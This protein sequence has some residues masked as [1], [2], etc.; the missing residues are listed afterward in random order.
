[1]EILKT[2]NDINLILGNTQDFKVDAGWDQNLQE[3]EKE[4]LEKIINPVENYETVRYIHKPYTSPNGVYQSD[5][6]FYFYFLNNTTGYTNGLD[7]S[8]VGI[9]PKENAKMLKQSTESFFRL[10]F[11]KTPNND[12]PDRTNRRLVFTK[13]LSLPLGEKFYYTTLNDF[14]FVPVFMGNNYKNTENMYLFWFQ[15]DTPFEETTITGNTFWMTAKFYNGKDGSILDFTTTGLTTSQEVNET[16]DMYYQ[17]VIDRTNYTYQ[18]FRYNGSVGSRIGLNNDP[19][20]F[21]EKI[22]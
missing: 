8:L 13:N 10:E 14:I 18:I 6:W 15:D 17:M 4:S 1:M 9:T 11:Y 19:I 2:N 16:N 5:I 22:M 7:Y 12:A 21:Y 3:L 20:L